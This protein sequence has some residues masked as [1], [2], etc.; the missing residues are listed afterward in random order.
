MARAVFRLS[1]FVLSLFLLFVGLNLCLP[2]GDFHIAELA[3]GIGF[4]LLGVLLFVFSFSDR[5]AAKWS[6]LYLPRVLLY[7]ALF[8]VST[9]VVIRSWLRSSVAFEKGDWYLVAIDATFLAFLAC[10][11]ISY[12]FWGRRTTK[13]QEP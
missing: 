4:A 2:S 11:A 1:D 8:V 12:A 13:L 3:A 6:R 9:G 10:N 7:S 5:A